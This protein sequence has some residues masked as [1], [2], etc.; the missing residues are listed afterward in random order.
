[1]REMVWLGEVG[2]D[3]DGESDQDREAG[4]TREVE[5]GANES[6]EG[7]T[8]VGRS[9]QRSRPSD[10]A[11]ASN[12]NSSRKSIER[13]LKRPRRKEKRRAVRK[14]LAAFRRFHSGG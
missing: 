4:R 9:D 13:D 5:V 1:M 6:V 7:K 14:D 10:N 2:E 11:S 12:H 3:S 8:V